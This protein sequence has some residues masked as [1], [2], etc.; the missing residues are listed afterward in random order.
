M[1]RKFVKRRKT[2][3]DGMGRKPL[4]EGRIEVYEF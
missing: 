4:V 2:H 1:S 3:V